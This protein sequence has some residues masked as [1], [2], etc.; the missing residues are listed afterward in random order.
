MG[1]SM[2]KNDGLDEQNLTEE[3]HVL[4]CERKEVQNGSGEK[5]KILELMEQQD[6]V[7]VVQEKESSDVIIE[8][9]TEKKLLYNVVDHPPISLTVISGLQHTLLS[10]SSSLAVSFLVADVVCAEQ[11][12]ELKSMI[13]SSNFF[14]NGLTT[15]IMNLFGIRL[16]LYQGSASDYLVPLLA[17]QV[18]DKGRCSLPET[19][20]GILLVDYL[21]KDKQ[22]MEYTML[23]FRHSYGKILNL[24]AAKSSLIKGVLL[25]QDNTPVHKSVTAMAAIH[26]C[27]FNLIGHP[28][29]SPDLAPSD[30]NL[31]P[32]LKAAISGIHTQPDDDVILAVDSFLT[33]QYKEFF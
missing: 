2:E 11:N 25:H 6:C 32:K 28:P 16:P 21:Q 14:M 24:S 3:H 30:F 26:D 31:F 22:S 18:V 17:V 20:E 1:T 29:Y 33:S 13:L 5:Q 8:D 4:L 10:L 27:G 15:I 19:F 23:H 7:T 9:L 12:E